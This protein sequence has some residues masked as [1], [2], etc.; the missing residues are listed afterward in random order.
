MKEG[1]K[2]LPL[3]TKIFIA[4]VL[5]IAVGLILLPWPEIASKY[6]KPL[7]TIFLNLIKWIVCP[8]VFFSIMAG[9][10]PCGISVK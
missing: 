1:K 6:I 9:S 5:A 3:A 8:L 2:K 7:G 4:M 10:Y